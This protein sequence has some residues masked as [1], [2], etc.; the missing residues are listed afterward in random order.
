MYVDSCSTNLIR[1]LTE[2]RTVAGDSMN[3]QIGLEVAPEMILKIFSG[4]TTFCWTRLH[5]DDDEGEDELDD[6]AE[7]KTGR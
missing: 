4:E 7:Q 6:P 1:G 2:C 3:W 5:H